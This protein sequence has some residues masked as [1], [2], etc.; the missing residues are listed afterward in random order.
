MKRY[1]AC[2]T[3]L[4]LCSS[5]LLG[6]CSEIV[7]ALDDLDKATNLRPAGSPDVVILGF[8]GRCGPPG[9]GAPS[10]NKAYLSDPDNQTLQALARTFE[11]LGHSVQWS[12]YAATVSQRVNDHAHP[13]YYEAQG[14]LDWIN[15]NWIADFD[16]PT[17][18][19]LAGHSHGA[20][21]A[22]LLAMENPHVTFDVG[23][24]LDGVCN[25]WE[26]DN[27]YYGF[28]TDSNLIAEFYRSV[29]EPYP[30]T[31]DALGGACNAYPVPEL[32]DKKH[33]KDVVPWNI[34]VG[35][36]IQ[37][38]PTFVLLPDSVGGGATLEAQGKC[39]GGGWV[40]VKDQNLNV[41]PDGSVEGL[42]MDYSPSQDHC[43]LVVWDGYAMQH[44]LSFFGANGLA[45]SSASLGD[46]AATRRQPTELN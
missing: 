16:N 7:E 8:A 35:I 42:Y 20:V 41:R 14:E 27:L 44:L 43:D 12:S 25:Q 15:A 11:S 9:C 22:S 3:T 1:R 26:Q 19:I 38:S 21:W 13:G 40:G 29:G 45:L 37:S 34:T 6:G 28:F 30:V 39:A 18:L 5:L 23:V 17:R 10:N 46:S 2:L 31:L 36:E 4:L 33:L 24:Y 32:S